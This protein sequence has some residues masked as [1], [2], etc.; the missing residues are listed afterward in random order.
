MFNWFPLLPGRGSG[1]HNAFHHVHAFHG[2]DSGRYKGIDILQDILQGGLLL[3][4]R[5]VNTR[6]YSEYNYGLFPRIRRLADSKG[7][8]L[9]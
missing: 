8:A 3:G 9:T 6:T 7:T 5:P 2:P 1:V 4:A